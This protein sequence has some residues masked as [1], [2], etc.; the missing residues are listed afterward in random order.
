MRLAK[1]VI[2]APAH[3]KVIIFGRIS[4]LVCSLNQSKLV[5]TSDNWG[6]CKTISHNDYDDDV[7]DDDDDVDNDDDGADDDDLTGYI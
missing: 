7:D 4:G 1:I 3:Q 2:S 6:R 5:L